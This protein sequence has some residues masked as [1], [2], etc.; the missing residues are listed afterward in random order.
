MPHSLR[1]RGFGA[2]ASGT[3]M[4]LM[5]I[6]SLLSAA[7]S[8][9]AG[10]IDG[11]IVGVHDGDSL[12]MLDREQ[13]QHKIRLNG[14]DAPELG[15]PFGQAAKLHLSAAAFDRDATAECHK[16]DRYGREVCRVFVD[17]VDI[18]LAQIRAG[19]AWF[20]KRYAGELKADGRRQ[21]AEAE[22]A[23]RKARR[24]LWADAEPVPPWEWRTPVTR[25]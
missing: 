9:Q 2:V 25:Q 3:T 13:R 14:I 8:V 24:G 11:R 21:Y 12:T 20:F 15:Q 1:G 17:G 7:A 22:E 23:A 10:T 18:G 4:R 19:L 6:C 16:T 5:L